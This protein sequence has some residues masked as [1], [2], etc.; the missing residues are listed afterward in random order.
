MNRI[1]NLTSAL[2]G[3]FRPRSTELNIKVY[4]EEPEETPE[5][6]VQEVIDWLLSSLLNAGYWSQAHLLLDDGQQDWSPAILNAAVRGEPIFLY[7]FGSQ[8]STP[9]EGTY[10]RLMGE[11][12]SLRVYQLEA[13]D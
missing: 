13:K 7:R 10:W 6:E 3:A 1:L 12:S 9:T 2:L 8:P 11:H 4:G 5:G